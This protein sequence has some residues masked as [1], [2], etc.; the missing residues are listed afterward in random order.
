MVLLGEK[1]E[2]FAVGTKG[3]PCGDVSHTDGQSVWIMNPTSHK[4]D[5]LS[6]LERKLGFPQT[7]L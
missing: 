7:Q 1:L 3:I 4:N 2:K 6:A 5:R